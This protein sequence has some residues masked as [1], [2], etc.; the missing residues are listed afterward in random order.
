MNLRRTLYSIL[1]LFPL[2]AT[3]QVPTI[4]D[5]IG[6]LEAVRD[7]KCYATANRL[8][9]FIYGT[10]LES[11][12][13]FA[14]IDLQ[15]QF[16]RS[17]W[18]KA[19]AAASAAGKSEVG[20]DELRAAIQGAV[21]YAQAADGSFTLRQTQITARDKRQYGSVAYALRA[22]LA[23]QQDALVDPSAKLLP[24]TADAVELFKESI[25]LTTL[26][27]LQRADR[28]SRRLNHERMQPAVLQAA[29]KQVVGGAGG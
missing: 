8:E 17:L 29:W 12:T 3:A 7:P 25:D 24:L 18:A 23:V 9:D 6:E 20:V 22:I 14:K 4:I 28:E 10:P 26:A 16:I 19:S 2:T 15:K 13:R 5:E 1:V 11:E 21:P 27:A